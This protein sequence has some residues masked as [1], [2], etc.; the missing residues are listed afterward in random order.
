LDVGA[1]EAAEYIRRFLRHPG[2]RTEKQRLGKVILARQRNLS[3]WEIGK[4]TLQR[5]SWPQP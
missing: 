3:F 5:L 1:S 4:P 2:F